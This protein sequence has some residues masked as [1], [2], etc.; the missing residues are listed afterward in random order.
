MRYMLVLIIAG[1]AMSSCTTPVPEKATEKTYPYLLVVTVPSGAT[2]TFTGGDTCETPC[3]VNVT[4]QMKMT[5]AKAGYKPITYTLYG[6]NPGE[7]LVEL[8]LV[9]PTTSVEEGALPDL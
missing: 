5:I 1:L 3:P 4:F 2:L 6:N 8:E 7:L 9:A